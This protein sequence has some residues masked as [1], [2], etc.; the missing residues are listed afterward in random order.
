MNVETHVD[1]EE[2]L[3]LPSWIFDVIEDDNDLDVNHQHK[4]SL[5]EELDIQPLII[6][7]IMLWQLRCPFFYILRWFP[8]LT[9]T[10]SINSNNGTS[11]S[12]CSCWN[13]FISSDYNTHP[14]KLVSSRKSKN[15]RIINDTSTSSTASSASSTTT[16]TIDIYENHNSSIDFW[17]PALTVTMYASLLWLGSQK[18]VPHVY[19]IWCIGAFMS[20][21]T[22]R[23]FLEGSSLSFHLSIL[24]YSLVPQIPLCLVIL[25]F[26][27]SLTICTLL[28]IICVAYSGVAAVMSYNMIIKP[29]IVRSEDRNKLLLLLPIVFLFEAY[30]IALMPM[31]R[32]QINRGQPVSIM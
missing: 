4:S 19:V 1:Q 7:E 16:T 27:P 9:S 14:I 12:I 8:N 13:R 5:L 30:I 20:H 11:L 28:Q 3:G 21:L 26:Q 32:F 17:G 2:T 23:P 22:T 18:N 15:S 31:R 25:L 24:G 10:T 29:L 6:M